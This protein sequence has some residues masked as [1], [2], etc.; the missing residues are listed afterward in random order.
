MCAQANR[1]YVIGRGPDGVHEVV[2]SDGVSSLHCELLMTEL[3]LTVRD[4]DS[5]NGTSVNDQPLPRGGMAPVRVG[6]VI[7][8]GRNA[9]VQVERRHLQWLTQPEAPAPSPAPAPAPSAPPAAP[10][11][12]VA[13]S[14]AAS[15]AL[16]PQPAAPPRPAP[17]PVAA[18]PAQAPAY[19][20]QKAAV[21]GNGLVSAFLFVCLAVFVVLLVVRRPSHDTMIEHACAREAKGSTVEK[22]ACHLAASGGGF[23][24]ESYG[25]LAVMSYREHRWIGVWDETIRLR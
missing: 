20:A 3:G 25:V 24:Y 21:S 2:Q 7:G 13:A 19:P 10:P 23:K 22:L 8:L 18:P 17:A 5:T 11:R 12:P 1:R 4:L 16:S 15:P 6:H 14:P 9:S